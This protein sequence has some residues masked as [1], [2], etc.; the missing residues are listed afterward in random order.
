MS[1]VS[2]RVQDS[3]PPAARR[4]TIVLAVV[5]PLLIT[6][7]LVAVYYLLPVDRE[8]QGGGLLLLIGELGVVVVVI[9]WQI[10]LILRA[11]Y[12]TLQGIEALA[13][14]VPLYL[15]V[16]A[17]VHYLLA[18]GNPASFTEPLSR[19][20]AL[21]FSVTVFTTVGFGDIAPLTQTARVLA[22]A[23]MV[24]NL[25][26]LGVALRVILTAVERGRLRKAARDLTEEP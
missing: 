11:R 23:Q 22:T 25:L 7:T 13:L 17:N 6:A 14:V 10:R 20:D 12:P 16:F 4:G 24:G 21:Y 9:V 19:T 18:D 2:P 8:L 3:E 26:V 5:R 15:L 1:V